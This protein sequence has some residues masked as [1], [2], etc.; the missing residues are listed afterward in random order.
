MW[1]RMQTY[2]VSVNLAAGA[3]VTNEKFRRNAMR[4]LR[5]ALSSFALAFATTTMPFHSAAAQTSSAQTWPAKPVRIIVS[6]AAGGTPDI[7]CRIVSER[8]AAA[9]G[10]QIVV[11]NHPGGANVIGAQ[12]AAKAAPDGYTLYFATAAAL[13][14]NPYTFKALPYDPLNDFV[15]IAMIAQNPFLVLA[16]PGVPAQN[17]AELIAYD[18]ANPGKL[19]FATDGPRNLS[20]MLAAW[21]NKLGGSNILQVPYAT[22]PQGVQDTLAGR[23]QLTVLAVPSAAPHIASGAL[24]ALATSSP[25]RL[26]NYPQI[27]TIGETFPGIEFSGWFALVAPAGVPDMAIDRVNRELAIILKNPDIVA[28]LAEL[29]FFAYDPAPP[30][31]VRA[32]VRGQYELWGK[33]TRDIG[34]KAE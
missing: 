8:L 19:A 5:V 11:E 25:A 1:M 20:G 24:R 17:V 6:L 16:H 7:I 4:Q 14:T 18:K 15:P 23:V 34:L 21:L 33:L 26:V 30:P 31:K 22:M 29:G 13:V 27:P 12:L 28:K 2:A 3:G 10:Q 32:Y 9:L